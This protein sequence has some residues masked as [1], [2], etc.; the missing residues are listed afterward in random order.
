MKSADTEMVRAM[1]TLH[2]DHGVLLKGAPRASAAHPELWER[3]ARGLKPGSDHRL[4]K[5][6]VCLPSV[7]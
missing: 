2:R 1:A 3:S 6:A 5:Q 4:S 7:T